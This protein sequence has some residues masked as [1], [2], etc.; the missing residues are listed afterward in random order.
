MT[1]SLVRAIHCNRAQASRAV[2]VLATPR[3]ATTAITTAHGAAGGLC[4]CHCALVD[5]CSDPMG[6]G[7]PLQTSQPSQPPCSQPANP[8]GHIEGRISEGSSS[9]DCSST[10]GPIL[11]SR[12]NVWDL[13]LLEQRILCATKPKATDA[14]TGAQG[15]APSIVVLDSVASVS[16]ILLLSHADVTPPAVTSSLRHM[17]HALLSL[18][19]HPGHS[20]LPLSLLLS[21]SSSH[22]P[23]GNSVVTSGMTISSSSTAGTGNIGGRGSSGRS[24]S[25]GSMG[26]RHVLPGGI[27]VLQQKRA[28]GKFRTAL[29]EFH[30]DRQ[31]AVHIDAQSKGSVHVPQPP[32]APSESPE[33]APQPTL[34]SDSTRDTS[35]VPPA[36]VSLPEQQPAEGAHR[37]VTGRTEAAGVEPIRVMGDRV[38]EVSFRLERSE[39]RQRE[40]ESGAASYCCF[41]FPS[42]FFLLSCQMN[43]RSPFA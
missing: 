39:E 11:S 36:N 3:A 19:P 28:S 23:S 22:H 10:A 9:A 6:W 24:E 32:T 16:G 17:A 21:P 33:T 35:K 29:E 41:P 4:A 18:E 1:E 12:C 20:L 8:S 7:Q 37:G 42:T 15:S 31:G 25:G 34:A 30:V 38:P 2:L 14:H 5:C 40:R 27:L 43:N 13:Q 26:D